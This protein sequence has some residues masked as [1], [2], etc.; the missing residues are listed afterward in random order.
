[1]SRAGDPKEV[2]PRTI[3][4]SMPSIADDMAPRASRPRAAEAARAGAGQS[5]HGAEFKLSPD[6]GRLACADG[7]VI[8]NQWRGDRRVAPLGISPISIF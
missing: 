5:F 7:A 4:F 6:P 2:D 3:L 1:M 8:R